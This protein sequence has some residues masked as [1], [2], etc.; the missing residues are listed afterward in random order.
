ML[1]AATIGWAGFA[2]FVTHASLSPLALLG[3]VAAVVGL[4]RAALF[5][6]EIAHL[7]HGVI[8][9][10]ETGW[11]LLVG[12][13]L[14]VPSLMYTGTHGDHH[15]HSQFG[16]EEDPEYERIAAWIP[17]RIALSFLTMLAVPLLLALRW[18][19]LGPLSYLFPPLRRLVIERASTL[20]INPAYR[21]RQLKPSEVWDWAW[22]EALAASVI[23]AMAAA[24]LTGAL[25]WTFL[26]K[27]YALPAGVLVLNHTRTLAAHRYEND[28]KAPLDRMGQLLD[29]INLTGRSW[30]T[31]LAA[32]VGQRFHALHHL[33][34]T[35]PYHSLGQVH[36]ALERELPAD[37]PYRL[38]ARDGIIDGMKGLFAYAR[39]NARA[40]RSAPAAV[41][42][43]PGVDTYMSRVRYSA[44]PPM[45]NRALGAHAATSGGSVP[46][47][48]AAMDSA[49]ADQ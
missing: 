10:F 23:W 21:R 6:H 39:R 24:C 45:P 8:D 17:A 7:K 5:I 14:L 3:Y 34:P 38:T 15:R 48:P 19:V 33:L 44:V 46:A 31:P 26:L 43:P 30:L 27:W 35:L 41:R 12:I 11:N 13:P 18:G 4:Y 42:R 47:C 29:S 36:R 20:V 2:L 32:P 40:G 9:G 28:S 1:A 16:T 25:E 49:V 37:S 22:Q